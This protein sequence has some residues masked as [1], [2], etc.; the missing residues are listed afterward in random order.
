MTKPM[1][2]PSQDELQRQLDYNSTNG[3]LR[4]KIKRNGGAKAGDLA[5]HI[6]K[7]GYR[8][9]KIGGRHRMAHRIVWAITYGDTPEDLQIDHINGNKLDNRLQNLRLCSSAENCSNRAANSRNQSGYKGVY[10]WK[11]RQAWRADIRSNGKQYYLGTFST[12]ELAHMAY[13]KAAA[14][15]HGDF[16]R[17]S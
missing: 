6:S 4:W 15:L 8:R 5:G 3:E 1:P 17:G 13:C 11:T 12:P 2:L 9:I 16:A 14:E 10:W 7:R